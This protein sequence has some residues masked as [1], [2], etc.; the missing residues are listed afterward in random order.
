MKIA[1]K[2]VLENISDEELKDL[3]EIIKNQ[4]EY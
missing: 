1:I 3:F 2:K 4:H